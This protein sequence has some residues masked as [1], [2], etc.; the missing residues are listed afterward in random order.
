M[1]HPGIRLAH[2]SDIPGTD[3][4]A[5][6]LLPFSIGGDLVDVVMHDR[7][8]IIGLIVIGA[9]AGFGQDLFVDVSPGLA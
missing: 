9:F 4:R 3:L 6:R 2:Q 1:R 5:L 7:M 8:A